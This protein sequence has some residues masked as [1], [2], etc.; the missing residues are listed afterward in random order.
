MA[1]FKALKE[2][3]KQNPL[4]VLKSLVPGG[5]VEGSDYIPLNPNR[6][7]RKIGSFRIN[8]AT[9]RFNDFAINGCSGGSI[10]D[11][12]AFVYGCDIVTAADKLSKLLFLSSVSSE[13]SIPE[14]LPD[15]KRKIDTAYVWNRSI[16]S[17]NHKYLR[18][19]RISIGNARINIYKG[20][21]KLVIPLTNS[22]CNDA[23][24]LSVKGLQFIEENGSKRFL[25]TFKGLLH[26]AAPYDYDKNIAVICE[27]YATARSIAETTGLFTIAAMAAC[28]V[29]NVALRI[30]ELL[31]QARI[32]IAADNDVTGLD[33][34][35]EASQALGYNVQITYPTHEKDSNDAF[36]AVG[37]ANLKTQILE[38]IRK[39]PTYG[40]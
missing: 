23:D 32:I 38:Q 27:G 11:L 9:G 16:K 36:I 14:D 25:G 30:R 17:E 31:P 12:V 39:E 40:E 3:Y 6:N 19:K 33:A 29:K 28:N 26:L 2:A 20:V 5:M 22:V 13:F 34:A 8:I 1:N 4:A 37:A 24:S 18:Q 15:K 10:I 7:D 21:K 35:E